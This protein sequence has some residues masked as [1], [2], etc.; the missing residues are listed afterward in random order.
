MRLLHVI[1]ISKGITKNQL[2]YFTTKNT[3]EG[4]LVFVPIRSR[5]VPALVLESVKIENV[6]SKIKA[7]TFAMKKVDGKQGKVFLLPQFVEAAE[8]TALYFASTTGA[9]LHQ[10]V[11][12]ILFDNIDSLPPPKIQKDSG[13]GTLTNEKL[14]LEANEETRFSD[15]KSIVREE[16]ARNS[17]VFISI[18]TIREA[19]NIEE[20]LKKGIEPYVFVL[21]SEVPKRE[22]LKRI[23]KIITEDHPVLIIATPAFLS[24][25]REDISTI[26]VER[27]SS[28]SFKRQTRPYIDM[29]VF[30]EKYAEALGI[31]IVFADMPLSINTHYRHKQGE[32]D[33]L[34]SLRTRVVGDADQY[35]VDM[36]KDKEGNTKFSALSSLLIENINEVHEAGKNSFL[37]NVRRGIAPTTVCED[38][39]SIVVCSKCESPV[40]LHKSGR[41]NVF[42]CHACGD[43]R[44]AKEVCKN[45]DSW[46]LKALG[47]GTERVRSELENI[48]PKKKIFSI[49]SDSTKT[50]K[51]AKKV[52]QD[53]YATKG[54]ILV[55]TELSLSF[56]SKPIDVTAVVSLDSLLSVP[57]ARIHEHIFSLILKIREHTN[58]S[59]FLQTRQP[60]LPVIKYATEGNVGGFYEKEILA[61]R[62]FDYPPF[63]T[64]IKISSYGD[65][66]KA[67]KELEYVES[68]LKD[69]NFAI[70]PG[71]T[72]IGEGKFALHGLLKVPEGRWPDKKL[73]ILL[74]S[75]PPYLSVNVLPTSTL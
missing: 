43:V 18:S 53:F 62:R 70:Y 3:K 74:R 63:A 15:F 23:E 64:L 29:R 60:E 75:L 11:P 1:P 49:D 38:C 40:V 2:S 36:R 52:A 56:L 73:I 26:I 55:G 24:I 50:Y 46:K 25:P 57:D 10:V 45:C 33:E 30:A 72:P 66:K 32:Y 47:I 14:I 58:T 12:K 37:F 39:G 61:R 7:S 59:F 44:S 34:K 51:Q 5:I 48:F 65:P 71:F 27:E 68:F 28:R 16:F 41:Q 42:L 35:I 54:G 4:E 21:H 69:Y 13:R 31:R 17:S 8:E 9:V 67:V 19:E 20:G 6:K 22:S